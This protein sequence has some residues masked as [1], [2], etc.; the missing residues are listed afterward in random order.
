[1]ADDP[2]RSYHFGLI[3]DGGVAASFV[4][5]SGLGSE[6]DV[7]AYREGGARQTVRHLPGQT[8][9]TPMTLRYGVTRS[10]DVW[11]WFQTAARG[12]VERRDISI[13]LFEQDGVSEAVR[14]NLHNAWISKWQAARLDAATSEVA[15][16]SVT[17]IYDR[18][19][20]D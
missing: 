11:D 3:L 13:V 16:E 4:E 19:E 1:M 5:C 20:R 6:I 9:M 10:T 18:V 2:Y 17:V 7:I 8:R 12:A 14:W 15:I